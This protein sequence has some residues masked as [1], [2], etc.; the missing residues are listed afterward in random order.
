M[1]RVAYFK[2]NETYSDDPHQKEELPAEEYDDGLDDLPESEEQPELS[3]EEK[4]DR[5]QNRIRF[6][7]GAGNLFGVVAGAVVILVVLTLIFSIIHF[8]VTDLGRSFSLFQ[9]NF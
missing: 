9:T 2:N 5:K 3:E 4:E 1:I 6:V 7:F 8:M